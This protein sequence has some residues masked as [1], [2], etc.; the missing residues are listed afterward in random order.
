MRTNPFVPAKA[1]TM[2]I[3]NKIMLI[4]AVCLLAACGAR[5][6]GRVSGGAVTGA[7]TGSTIGLIAGPPGVL[8]GGV[9]GGGVGAVT[10]A[11]TSPRQ[12]NLG[13]P[14]WNR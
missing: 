7:A 8:V 5:Q 1:L 14:L 12:V 4:G 3:T 9:V 2:N 6:P 11:T 10:A 13:S